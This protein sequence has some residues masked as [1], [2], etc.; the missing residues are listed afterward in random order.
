M[1]K[2]RGSQMRRRLGLA[3]ERLLAYY[4][5]GRCR[6]LLGQETRFLCHFARIEAARHRNLQ[7]LQRMDKWTR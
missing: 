2:R 3:V 6:L 5:L 1:G 4:V 7:K